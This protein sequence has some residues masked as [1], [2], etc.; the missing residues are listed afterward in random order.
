MTLEDLYRLLRGGHVQL[1]GIVETLAEPL[2]VLDQD[3]RVI[4]VNPAFLDTF[5]VKREDTLERSLFDLGNGQWNIAD[6]RAL[7]KNV[8]PK[9]AAIV[10]YEVTHDFPQLGERVILVSARRLWNP[11][12]NS[13]QVLVVFEDVTTRQ[14]EMAAKGIFMSETHHRMKNLLAVVHSLAIQT[15]AEGKTGEEYRDAFLGRF[16]TLIDSQNFTLAN[17]TKTDFTTIVQRV[18]QTANSDRIR[19]EAGPQVHVKTQQALPLAMILHELLTNAVKFGALGSEEG[20]VHIGWSL[21]HDKGEPRLLFDWREEGGPMVSPPAKLGFGTELIEF[22]AMTM[23][24]EA[25][26]QYQPS[27]FH[28]RVTLPVD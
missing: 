10:G 26:L 1:Q 8:V 18:V 27:G 9:S 28:A 12:Q 6:L 25:D 23:M 14:E 20:R 3:L 24:G 11:D 7:L 22:S 19:L 16:Q 5:K 2:V 4:T 17:A 15:T 21:K 13:I